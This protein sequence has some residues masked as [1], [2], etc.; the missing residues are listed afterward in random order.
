MTMKGTEKII[1]HIEA[2]AKKEADAILAAAEAEAKAIR[3]EYAA[4]AE[5]ECARISE[6]GKAEC[7]DIVARAKRMGEMESKKGILAVKQEMVS[8]AFAEACGAILSMPAEDYVVFLAQLA[9]EASSNGMEEVVFNAKDKAECAKEVCKKANELIAA[10]GGIGKLTVSED[11]AD[12][13]GGL[14]I[15]QGGIEANCSI[16]KMIEQ[17]RSSMSAEVA[18]VLFE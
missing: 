18:A 1:A 9:A 5:A 3:E 15:R 8:E 7:A 13:A 14:I 17:S 10:K 11:T 6:S 12:I 16:E 4:K 2:E